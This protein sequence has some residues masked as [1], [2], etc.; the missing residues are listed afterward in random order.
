MQS[1]FLQGGPIKP[2]REV[3][4]PG[5]E[6]AE[7]EFGGDLFVGEMTGEIKSKILG[8]LGVDF[9]SLAQFSL[10]GEFNFQV[11]QVPQSEPTLFLLKREIE[12]ETEIIA[13][14][15]EMLEIF[16]ESEGLEKKPL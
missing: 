3:A 8:V 15:E 14:E 7:V 4:L 13:Y 2:T 5:E 6:V 12:N 10:E 11:W 16:A 9:D 1:R